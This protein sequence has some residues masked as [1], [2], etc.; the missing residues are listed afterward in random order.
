MPHEGG[1]LAGAFSFK[2]VPGKDLYT[3]TTAWYGAIGAGAVLTWS[4]TTSTAF[5]FRMRA[6]DNRVHVT[7]TGIPLDGTHKAWWRV[8]NTDGANPHNTGYEFRWIVW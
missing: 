1:Y 3:V 8:T 2:P 7:E 4:A 5:F 6:D